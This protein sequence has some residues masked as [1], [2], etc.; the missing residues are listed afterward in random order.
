MGCA[1]TLEGCGINEEWVARAKGPSITQSTHE[2][3][4][5]FDQ[6]Y[7]FYINQSGECLTERILPS[8]PETTRW[9]REWNR[10]NLPVRNTHL[11]WRSFAS[12]FQGMGMIVVES[13]DAC[14]VV[15]VQSVSAFPVLWRVCNDDWRVKM[16]VRINCCIVNEEE[17]TMIVESKWRWRW[18]YLL[19]KKCEQ[20]RFSLLRSFSFSL[21]SPS[22]LVVLFASSLSCFCLWLQNRGLFFR[23]FWR[24]VPA[25][26]IGYRGFLCYAVGGVVNRGGGWLRERNRGFL[27]RFR[28]FEGKAFPGIEDF[29]SGKL[30]RELQGDRKMVFFCTSWSN[31]VEGGLEVLYG[32]IMV[33][34]WRGV[35]E[36][37]EGGLK[38]RKWRFSGWSEGPESFVVTGCRFFLKVGRWRT[39]FCYWRGQWWLL[40]ELELVGG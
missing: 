18:R 22:N 8:A 10:F 13:D 1:W 11:Q 23:S 9:S 37:N 6:E 33:R 36:K 5:T 39:R 21:R 7:P 4:F 28:V 12:L 15:V 30:P 26:S 31:S 38:K 25:F 14:C 20:G 24:W 17:S 34:E 27:C 32:S 35:V 2:L 29:D 40:K 16:E 3:G 19:Q